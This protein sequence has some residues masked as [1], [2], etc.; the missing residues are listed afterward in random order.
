M[1]K[2]N[3]ENINK[4]SFWLDTLVDNAVHKEKIIDLTTY[5]NAVNNISPEDICSYAK[6]IFIAHDVVEVVMKP[7]VKQ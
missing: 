6:K 5:E 1:I 7:L 3:R 2:L 4:D